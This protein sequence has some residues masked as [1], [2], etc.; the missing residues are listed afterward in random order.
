MDRL[1]AMK[2]L[3]E[4]ADA[5]SL[6]AAARRLGMPLATVSRRISDLEGHLRTQIFI[7]GARELTLTDA[8]RGYVSSCRRILEDLSEAERTAAGEYVEPRGG[9]TVAAPVVFGRLHVAPLLA[10]FLAAYPNV[11]VRLD[12]S[13]RVADLTEQQIDVAVRI[14]ELSDGALVAAKVGAT[15]H[16]TCASPA[17]LAARGA[18][19]S[20]DDL[21]GHD[22]VTFDRLDAP[23]RWR[24]ADG[25]TVRI[26]SRLVV[27][28]AEAAID[29]AIAGAGVTRA[30]C[31]QTARAERAGDL[32]RLLQP[33][34]PPAAP[35]HVVYP[36]QGRLPMKVRAF[37]EFLAPR[38]RASLAKSDATAR[39]A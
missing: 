29:V 24:Y 33:F 13:D 35:I 5:G 15:R 8:G 19:Q 38:L 7:R 37:L 32:V 20:L 36:A 14:G 6:S 17:Y 31:Y 10:G 1:A 34:E 9:L 26:Q 18:P 23:D 4:A 2:A 27:T 28:T 21:A 12:L 16:V 30:L 22:C 11:A 3:V 39:P 25:A